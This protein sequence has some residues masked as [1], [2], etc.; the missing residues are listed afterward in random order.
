MRRRRGVLG[1]LSERHIIMGKSAVTPVRAL[2]SLEA[3]SNEKARED[4][5]NAILKLAPQSA[6]FTQNPPI[7]NQVQLVGSTFTTYKTARAASAASATQHKNDV[8]A[9]DQ[10]RVTNDRALLVL[11]HM[12]EDAAV[13]LDDIQSMAFEAYAGRPPP[14]S[15]VA[16]LVDVILGRKGSGRARPSVHETGGTRHRYVAE[17]SPDPITATSWSSLPGT[18]KSRKLSG[19][20]GTSV[21]VRFAMLHGQQQGDWSSP[22]LVTF[23]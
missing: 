7:Q 5:V 4:L 16:P 1:L 9:E 11:K 13:T 14:P 21:W 3:L 17:M 20:S 22:V 18:G 23:P 10:A 2:L 12:T 19:K 8:A 15:M 6:L